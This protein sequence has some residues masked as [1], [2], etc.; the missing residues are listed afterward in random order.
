MR[1]GQGAAMIL[2]RGRQSGLKFEKVPSR[3][4]YHWK[5]GGRE[6]T[7][8]CRKE[9]AQIIIDDMIGPLVTISDLSEF[10]LLGT[11]TRWMSPLFPPTTTTLDVVLQ[12]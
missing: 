5:H 12:D 7:S 2:G 9:S 3:F 10:Q 6:L 8:P 1:E 11:V 4:I